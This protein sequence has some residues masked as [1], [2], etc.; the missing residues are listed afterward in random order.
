MTDNL[1]IDFFKMLISSIPEDEFETRLKSF[2]IEDR[3]IKT[4]K[5]MAGY[6]AET[7]KEEWLW[8]WMDKA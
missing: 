2:G 1:M 8:I 7:K 5:E 4:L 6:S 3:H